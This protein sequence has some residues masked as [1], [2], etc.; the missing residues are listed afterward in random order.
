MA[1][2]SKYRH[3]Y[4][5][6]RVDQDAGLDVPLQERISVTKVLWTEKDAAL[7]VGLLR[8]I[9]Y[10]DQLLSRPGYKIP[11]VITA[12]RARQVA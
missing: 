5:I 12:G 9:E 8:T 2:H 7:E 11:S 1:S 10:F 3:V 4:A 6:V